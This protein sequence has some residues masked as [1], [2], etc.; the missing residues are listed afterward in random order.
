V[1]KTI[2]YVLVTLLT[3]VG[4]GAIF[5]FMISWYSFKDFLYSPI[6]FAIMTVMS[7]NYWL[8]PSITTSSTIML[9]PRPSSALQQSL[10]WVQNRLLWH[11]NRAIMPYWRRMCG[12]QS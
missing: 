3:L 7:H 2:D 11:S 8:F 9:L 6:I 4:F 1:L 12:T 5:C 10:S